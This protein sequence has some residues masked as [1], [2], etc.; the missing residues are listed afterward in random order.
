MKVYDLI[1]GIRSGVA[2]L[3]DVDSAA[4]VL[5]T[6][7]VGDRETGGA[8]T[9]YAEVTVYVGRDVRCERSSAGLPGEDNVERVLRDCA[10]WLLDEM[11]KAPVKGRR[12]EALDRYAAKIRAATRDSLERDFRV[13]DQE[14][15]RLSHD[16]S[17][18]R[19]RVEAQSQQ[20]VR[21]CETRVKT[22][23]AG[24]LRDR[25]V[26][27]AQVRA[28]IEGGTVAALLAEWAAEEG[29]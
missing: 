6:L 16:L 23:E 14:N 17:M 28:A 13:L 11:E 1:E 25:A 26:L 27:K 4:D 20:H 8:L 21:M 24:R 12:R 29:S 2:E 19:H 10:E 15:T 3:Y 7:D 22:A 18:L 9:P 5:V